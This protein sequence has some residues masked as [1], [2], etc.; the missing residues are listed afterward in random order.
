MRRIA[1]FALLVFLAG[2]SQAV[3]APEEK[4]AAQATFAATADAY[5]T[6]S[7]P[8]GNFGRARMLRIGPGWGGARAYVR[9]RVRGLTEPVRRATLRVYSRAAARRGLFVRPTSGRWS[10]RRV[11]FRNGPRAGR[12]LG[13][14]RRVRRGWLNIPLSR[15]V[16][17]NGTFNFVLTGFSRTTLS[18]REG[19]RRPQL[20]VETEPAPQTL[21]AA[22]DIADCFSNGDEQTAAL[23]NTIPGTVAALGDL[24]YEN[25]AP[26]EFA[27]CYEPTWG[28]FKA[29]T[30]PAAGNHEYQT[31]GAAGY[32][33]YWGATAGAPT[34][35]WYSYDLGAWHVVVL[36]SNCTFVGGCHA[37]SPQEAWL[38]QDLAANQR[39][40][41]LA[42]WHHPRFS[43]GS[44]GGSSSVGPLFQALYD[45]NAEAL[46]VGHAHNYQ[47]WV[48]QNPS[49]ARD[50][51]RGVRQFVVGTGGRVQHPVRPQLPNQEA[52]N[53]DTFG[54]LR[55]TLRGSA[56]DWQF[57]PVA[58]RTF[59][60]SGSQSCH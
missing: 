6:A 57:V 1:I 60:D 15:Y 33:A 19:G 23:V 48:P 9:F 13:F 58:G 26:H 10:E 54:V 52:V 36:N 27:Q 18:S 2:G 45:A 37:G 50:D 44:V 28:Q 53:D 14:V 31:P 38:R 16:N 43:S 12:A 47:R 24:A 29:R 32:F 7:S 55:L 11:T 35:G 17:G 39:R 25:G 46:L 56:F 22:G 34:Q 49:G 42:Y 41:T 40:C 51:Q 3:S 59:T 21:V 5:V 4:R 8:R 20:I 30:R